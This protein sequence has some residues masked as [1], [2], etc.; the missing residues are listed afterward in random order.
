MQKLKLIIIII[1]LS[2]TGI[3]HSKVTVNLDQP[4]PFQFKAENMWKVTLNNTG[5]EVMLEPEIVI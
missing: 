2:T 4:P 1:L 3:L 5:A